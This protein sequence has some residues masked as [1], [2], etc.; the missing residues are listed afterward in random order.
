SIYQ[1]TN[2]YLPTETKTIINDEEI[3]LP[4]V[5]SNP[6]VDSRL[7][8]SFIYEG[9]NEEYGRKVEMEITVLENVKVEMETTGLE[10]V[11]DKQIGCINNI[12]T[13]DGK[14][15]IDVDLI[16]FYRGEQALKE[17]LKDNA[18][19]VFSYTENGTPYIPNGYY[20]RN[21]SSK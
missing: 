9:F 16:E 20:I 13:I 3:L 6:Q 14:T 5:W 15:Y 2:Y 7:P 4:I 18:E 11:Y 8:G 19:K 12:Y 1:N 10:N 17:A 21:E